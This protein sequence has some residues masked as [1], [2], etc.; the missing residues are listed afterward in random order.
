MRDISKFVEDADLTELDL[1]VLN[2]II[3]NIDIVLQEGVR[4]IARKNYTSPATVIRLAK[5]L[6]YKGFIDLYYTLLPL[7]K[8]IETPIENTEEDFFE[9]NQ[10]DFFKYNPYE[11]IEKCIQHVLN[12]KEKYIFIYAAGFSTIAAEYL[13]K[14]C[15]LLGK[16]TIMAT[17]SDSIGVFENNLDNIGAFLSVSKSG[18]TE[19]VIDKI[20][21]AKENDIYTVSFTKETRNRVANLSDLNLRLEDKYQLDD[22]NLIPNTFYPR[23]LLLFEFIIKE[24]I[25]LQGSIKE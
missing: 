23:L 17:S 12:L 16:K 24:Y 3:E 21:T 18:E 10:E 15:L 4:E 8:N 25:E 1:K 19:S 20:K 13:Y 9:I 5:K 7:V 6:G 2:Y 14:K 11:A 22:R